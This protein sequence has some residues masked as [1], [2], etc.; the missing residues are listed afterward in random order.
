MVRTVLEE[1]G[2][3]DV[4]AELA[5][6]FMQQGQV[7]HVKRMDPVWTNRGKLMALHKIRKPETEGSTP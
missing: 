7:L 2:K 5:R 3:G 4:A 6:A 1:L